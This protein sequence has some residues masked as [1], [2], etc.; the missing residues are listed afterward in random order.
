MKKLLVEAIGTFFLV[1]TIGMTVI[2]PGAGPLAPL[3]IGAALAVMIFAGGHIS[4]GHYNPAVSFA[5]AIRG[6]LS[7]MELLPYWI[8]QVAGALVA[9]GAVIYL[10]GGAAPKAMAPV[11]G[12]ALLAEFL[13]TFALCYVVLNVATAKS[14]KGNSFYGWAIGFTVLTGAFAVG[15]ISG[16]AFNP[17]VAIG[18]ITMKIVAAGSLWIYLVANLLGGAAA[19]TVF[20][21][22]NGKE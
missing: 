3:A 12:P 11:A 17:A 7:W 22:T 16:G 6:A 18:L 15:G 21:F 5:A 10:K 14:T 13:F 9:S 20:L 1:F 2:D 4:G 8:A 19:A